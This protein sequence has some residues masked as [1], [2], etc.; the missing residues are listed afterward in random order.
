MTS[1]GSVEINLV[2]LASW[3]ALERAVRAVSMEQARWTSRAAWWHI[4]LGGGVC[5]TLE[6]AREVE[7]AHHS[8]QLECVGP[9]VWI[10]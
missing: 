10:E 5:V 4:P 2:W 1:G 8:Y 6:E 7:S 9:V 3:R